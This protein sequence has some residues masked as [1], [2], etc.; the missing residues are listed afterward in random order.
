MTLHLLQ[1][2]ALRQLHTYVHCVGEPPVPLDADRSA[3]A[4]AARARWRLFRRLRPMMFGEHHLE[5]MMWQERLSR[6]VL[7]DLLRSYEEYLVCVVT[8]ASPSEAV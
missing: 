3:T 6:D 2:D 8:P 1:C 4:D 7:S 5:E